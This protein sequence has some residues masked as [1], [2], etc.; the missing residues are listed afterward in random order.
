[1]LKKERRWKGVSEES[2]V[3]LGVDGK[4]V[5]VYHSTLLRHPKFKP[6]SKAMH[7]PEHRCTSARSFLNAITF[8]YGILFLV[9]IPY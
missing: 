9:C 5:K 1:M 6:V 4:T 8:A 3:N 2:L 7:T